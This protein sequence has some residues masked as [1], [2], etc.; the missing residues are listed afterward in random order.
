M[1]DVERFKGKDLL[2]HRDHA[3]KLAKNEFFIVDLIGLNVDEEKQNKINSIGTNR[4]ALWI[5]GVKYI[6]KKPIFGYG[7]EISINLLVSFY[8]SRRLHETI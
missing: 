4:G 7:Y 1:N 2:V 3:V 6:I 8:F 5:N